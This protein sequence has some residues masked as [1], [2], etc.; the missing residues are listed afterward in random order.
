MKYYPIGYSLLCYKL[1]KIHTQVFWN[2][3]SKIEDVTIS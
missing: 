2:K 3:Q 1:V